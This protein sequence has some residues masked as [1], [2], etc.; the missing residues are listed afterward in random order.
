MDENE[1]RAKFSHVIFIIIAISSP[2]LLG[3][4]FIPAFTGD[5]LRTSFLGSQYADN[6]TYVNQ[7]NPDRHYYDYEGIYI[8]NFSETY[9]HFNFDSLPTVSERLYFFLGG[10]HYDYDC[11]HYLYD[12]EINIIL[13]ESTWN[14][15]EITW[16]NKPQHD[17]IL[18]TGNASKIRQS[19]FIESYD[20]EKAVDLTDFLENQQYHEI[21]LC[22]N[23]TDNNKN[24]KC[25]IRL[26]GFKFLWYYEKMILSYTTIITSIIIFSMLIGITYFLRRD[27]FYCEN[28][29]TKRKLTDKFCPSCNIKPDK[30]LMTKETDYLIIL[31]L[32]WTFILIEGT[33]LIIMIFRDWMY[34]YF[35]F[36]IPLLI[37]PWIILCF[38][39][40]K[41]KY[42]IYKIL[43]DRVKFRIPES[44]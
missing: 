16:N 44:L 39:Q 40:I 36:L 3:I 7:S 23:I 29:N 31:I 35:P 15:S 19:F 26:Y 28:C 5:G 9:F 34:V 14:A 10:Y 24:L 1:N 12:V 27:I 32:L 38:T 21:S 20:L 2:F 42:K 33:F 37:I 18:Y 30:D 8:G 4:N 17:D 25:P 22:I 41:K 11:E 43:R 13:I 6:R